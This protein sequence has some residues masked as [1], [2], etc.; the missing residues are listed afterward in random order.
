MDCMIYRGLNGYR[1]YTGWLRETDPYFC[2]DIV[3]WKFTYSLSMFF[4]VL[5][6]K[7]HLVRKQG[8]HITGLPNPVA[9]IEMN[10]L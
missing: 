2:G 5:I 6:D 4:T 1:T 7:E 8:K 9:G 10:Q 3:R